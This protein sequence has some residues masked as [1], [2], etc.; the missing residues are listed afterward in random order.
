MS[1]VIIL[2]ICGRWPEQ[3]K[4]YHLLPTMASLR[5]LYLP[6]KW[7]SFSLLLNDVARKTPNLRKL[8]LR[9]EDGPSMTMLGVELFPTLRDMIKSFLDPSTLQFLSEWNLEDFGIVNPYPGIPSE[10]ETLLHKI[11]E[12]IPSIKLLYGSTDW[13]IPKG[14]QFDVGWDGQLT[15]MQKHW[16]T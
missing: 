7:D 15:W 8:V 2:E 6:L 14:K 5:E 13:F 11:V 16:G 3:E 4:L 12:V 9:Y 10:Y 1:K